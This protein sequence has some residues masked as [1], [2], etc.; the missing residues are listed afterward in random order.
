[1]QSITRNINF[2]FFNYCSGLCKSKCT[3]GLFDAY[4]NT[5]LIIDYLGWLAELYFF[6]YINV[7]MLK[8]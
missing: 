3:V 1:M 7:L 2:E 8:L 4:S 5:N 6:I